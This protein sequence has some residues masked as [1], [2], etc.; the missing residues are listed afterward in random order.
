ML[1]V[2]VIGKVPRLSPDGVP[3]IVAVPLPLSLK[4]TEI[5]SAPDSV[6]AGA[7]EPVVVTVKLSA[8]L[9]GKLALFALVI[10]GALVPPPPALNAAMAAAQGS[11][12]LSV[13][14]DEV[15]PDST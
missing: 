6:R 5:G 9:T 4:V 15:E 8:A 1:A 14:L 7:G 13:A 2:I 12:E 10:V 11:A 3:A